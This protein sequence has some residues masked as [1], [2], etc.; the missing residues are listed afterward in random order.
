MSRETVPARNFEA[1]TPSDTT[2]LTKDG[3]PPRAI[4]VGVGGDVSV[5]DTQDGTAVVFV[6]VPTGTILPIRP[7]HVRSTGTTATDMV[8][9][10]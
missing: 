5:Q 8:A 7:K 4:Y 9:L 1:I 3:I 6:G 10:Y 2:D